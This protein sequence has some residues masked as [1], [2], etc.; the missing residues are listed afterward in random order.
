MIDVF[1]GL[2][3]PHDEADA[4]ARAAEDVFKGLDMVIKNRSTTIRAFLKSIYDI[5]S[6]LHLLSYRTT[7]R[8]N[9]TRYIWIMSKLCYKILEHL[10]LM[11]LDLVGDIDQIFFL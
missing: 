1:E 5:N 9:L 8:L 7:A 3:G 4:D 6:D 10:D 11:I 2:N